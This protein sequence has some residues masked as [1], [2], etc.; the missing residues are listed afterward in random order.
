MTLTCPSCGTSYDV[1]QYPPGH[2]FDCTCGQPLSV[3]A[4]PPRV[5][6][7]PGLS[8]GLKALLFFLNLCVTPV[9]GIVWYFVIRREKPATAS[10]V[11]TFTWIPFVIW[12]GVITMAMLLGLFAGA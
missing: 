2:R 11:C 6:P 3:P 9:V 4:T 12:L 1:S 8:G 5:D 7:D 10:D